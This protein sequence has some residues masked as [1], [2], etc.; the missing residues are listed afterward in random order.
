MNDAVQLC[1]AF[2]EELG[3]GGGVGWRFIQDGFDVLQDEGVEVRSE[4]ARRV[5]ELKDKDLAIVADGV[6][7]VD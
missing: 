4:Q 6:V 3:Q 7:E 5:Q 2:R 1:V